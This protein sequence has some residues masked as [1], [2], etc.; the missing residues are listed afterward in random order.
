MSTIHLYSQIA[1]TNTSYV[2]LFKSSVRVAA[3]A[4]HPH[5]RAAVV[6]LKCGKGGA[7]EAV[8]EEEKKLQNEVCSQLQCL[9]FEPE[10]GI[11]LINALC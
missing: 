4:P 7:C 9:F 5:L 1:L 2:P 10:S 3:R 11:C 8:V 6:P